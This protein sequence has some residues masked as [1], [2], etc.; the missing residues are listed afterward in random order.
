MAKTIDPVR[1]ELYKQAR[2]KGASKEESMIK[3]GLSPNTAKAQNKSTKLD[4]VGDAEILQELKETDVTVELIIKRL[5][6]DRNLA[7]KKKDYST[8]TRVDELLGK[9]KAMFTDKT[10]VSGHITHSKEE[11]D[12]YNRLKGSLVN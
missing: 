9:Y 1:L 7:I 6:E 2:I 11:E 4:K 8:A 3:A 5:D 10:E 12:E